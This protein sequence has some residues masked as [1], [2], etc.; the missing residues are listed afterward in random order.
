MSKVTQSYCKTKYISVKISYPSDP[1]ENEI[2]IMCCI[3]ENGVA[4]IE[5]I[6][7]YLFPEWMQAQIPKPKNIP[8][9][10]QVTV[11]RH[12]LALRLLNPPSDVWSAVTAFDYFEV[13][14]KQNL[15]RLKFTN[16]GREFWLKHA[17]TSGSHKREN[18]IFFIPNK[19]LLTFNFL[20]KYGEIPE[21]NQ[22]VE[23]IKKSSRT[24]EE[25]ITTFDKKNELNQE[26]SEVKKNDNSSVPKIIED[27]LSITNSEII[28]KMSISSNS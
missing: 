28:D 23:F 18:T 20:E 3:R 1:D 4:N 10:I 22:S 26:N 15:N 27:D 21:K 7:D 12:D 2:L 5:G 8:D 11:N 16:N 24:T 14:N 19:V 25:K 6:K 13:D 9:K 17:G